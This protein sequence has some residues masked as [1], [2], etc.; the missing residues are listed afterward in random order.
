[1][2]LLY[3]RFEHNMSVEYKYAKAFNRFFG[4]LLRSTVDDYRSS[5]PKSSAKLWESLCQRSKLKLPTQPVESKYK[6]RSEH[7]EIRASL[8]LEECR[9]NLS[10]ALNSTPFSYSDK[11]RAGL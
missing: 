1:V 11:R 4:A 7:F 2:F 8:I 3:C 6:T 5:T 10:E 9:H